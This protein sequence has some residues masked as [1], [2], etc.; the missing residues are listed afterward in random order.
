MIT[1]G[2]T[3]RIFRLEASGFHGREPDEHRWNIDAGKIDSW[4]TRLTFNPGRNWSFQYSLAYLRSP[5]ALQPLEDVRRMTASLSYNRPLPQISG[6]T[7]NDMRMVPL[8]TRATLLAML[9]AGVTTAVTA[10]AVRTIAIVL[11]TDVV[12]IVFI[13]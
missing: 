2:I 12:G 10:R 8:F 7:L 13:C 9:W 1:L 4:S 5:E 3:H 11:G 6:F